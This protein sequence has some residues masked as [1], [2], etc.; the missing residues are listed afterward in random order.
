[1]F[2][3]TE[4]VPYP[5]H[6]AY[7]RRHFAPGNTD[8]WFAIEVAG[9]MVGTIALYDITPDGRHAEWGRFVVAPPYRGR[10][11]GRQALELLIEEARACGIHRLYCEVL[12]GNE[13]AER[14]YRGLGFRETGARGHSGRRFLQLEAQL[15][16]EN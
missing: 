13:R 2:L 16:P 14:L 9:R 5:D 11:W 15:V 12:A 1:M 4:T 8:R 7:V 3:N 10:G 6:L